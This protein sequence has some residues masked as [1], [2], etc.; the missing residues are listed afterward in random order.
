M[1]EH[2]HEL[3]MECEDKWGS[4]YLYDLHLT[5]QQRQ[6]PLQAALT[7]RGPGAV[8]AAGGG[9]GRSRGGGG[10]TWCHNMVL[11]TQRCK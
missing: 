9:A 5:V 6:L 8:A 1:Y 4:P 11:K 10:L 7:G 3:F 2:E